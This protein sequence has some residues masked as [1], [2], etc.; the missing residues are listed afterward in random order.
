MSWRTTAAE[1]MRHMEKQLWRCNGQATTLA[2]G[3]QWRYHHWWQT[4]INYSNAQR[5]M[6]NEGTDDKDDNTTINKC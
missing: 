5:Q 2:E 4:T 6:S 1:E 3:W